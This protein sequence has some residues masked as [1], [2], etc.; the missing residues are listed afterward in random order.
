MKARPIRC[1]VSAGPT[2]E[3]FDPVRFLS[4]PS[5][6][7]MGYALATAAQQRGWDVH[8]VSGPVHL[9]VPDGVTCE[10]VIT[11]NDMY[12]AIQRNFANCDI[13]IMTAAIMDYR[14]RTVS[15][16]KIKKY[17]LAMAL[18][19][20]PVVDVLATVAQNKTHQLVVGFAAETDN[21]ETYA[22]RKLAAK[23]ADFIVANSIAG[24]DGAFGRDNNTVIV[25]SAKGTR[26]PIG[27][28]P[29]SE[30]AA[31]LLDLFAP[32]IISPIP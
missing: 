31:Q 1:L 23:N 20:E 11:G 12:A 13:L 3:F 22:L 24:P 4:N 9:A 26:H 14:P 27:P 18:E 21:L 32:A 6:G 16:H 29:K 10:Q 8:L 15:P 25:Y 19:M 5:T 7:K 2:R 30:C 28:L 17:D